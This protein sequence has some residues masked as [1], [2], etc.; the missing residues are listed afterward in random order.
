MLSN[1]YRLSDEVKSAIIY[2]I[3]MVLSKGLTIITTPIF[4]RIMPSSDIGIVS[5]YNS[6]YSILSGIVTLGLTSGGL[7]VCLN[8]YRDKKNEYL[9]SILT[10]S[11]LSALLFGLSYVLFP[12]TYR[13]FL[14][15]P[16][17]IIT[18]MFVRFLFCPA[19]DFWISRQR[20]EYRYKLSG[21]VM[22]CSS[23]LASVLSVVAVFHTKNAQFFGYAES[24]IWGSS[25]VTI[26]V[27]IV[28]WINILVKGKKTFNRVYWKTSLKLSLPLIGQ[29]LASQLLSFSDRIMIEKYCGTS[30]VGIY[31]TVY[32]IGTL[33]TM[34]WTAVN[35][36]FTPY[37]YKNIENNRENIKRNSF[38]LLSIFS[39]IS[40]FVV[41]LGPEITRIF[42][43][44]EY[45]EGIYII[46]PVAAG[47]YLISV[48]DIYS[49]LLIYSQK[50]KYIMIGT[51][52]G[53]ITN[54][55]LNALLIPLFGYIAAAYTTLFAYVAMTL[56]II[57][58]AKISLKKTDVIIDDILAHKKVFFLSTLTIVL[59]L[60]CVLSY[61]NNWLRYFL[62]LSII[63]GA[64]FVLKKHN[65]VF[66]IKRLLFQRSAQ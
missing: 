12:N 30:E 31:S 21:I 27:A 48:C 3:S 17:T 13:N 46:P 39:F 18:L 53:A 63:V 62:I 66:E 19:Y 49:D 11:S 4:T 56:V 58:F 50:T 55:I 7:M 9:S 6:W 22:I 25:V 59:D 41:L 38:V 64:I 5:I 57:L 29:M 40:L 61:T 51:V 43:T 45:Y 35:G 60:T 65:V 37:I 8:E 34:L 14:G 26:G 24:R 10:L 44:E 52:F 28:I 2:L 36:T 20:Y 23:I 1:K 33:T 47:V 15:L 54:M 32:T 16:D 42:G